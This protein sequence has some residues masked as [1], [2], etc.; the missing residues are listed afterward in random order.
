ME[1][2]K[3]S[4]GEFQ[5]DRLTDRTFIRLPVRDLGR[6]RAVGWILLGMAA[7]GG[8]FSMAW[9]FNSILPGIRM[10]ADGEVFAI[11]QLLFGIFGLTGLVPAVLCFAFG[12]AILQNRVRGQ[13]EINDRELVYRES[14]T[15]F[16]KRVARIKLVDLS[17]F[18]LVPFAWQIKA[19]SGRETTAATSLFPHDWC[20]LQ[21]VMHSQSNGDDKQLAM[22]A[23]GY[24]YEVLIALA[25]ILIGEIGHIAKRGGIN[26]SCLDWSDSVGAGKDGAT[27]RHGAEATL[28]VDRVRGTPIAVAQPAGSRIEILRTPGQPTVFRLPAQGLSGHALRLFSFGCVWNGIVLLMTI[29]FIVVAISNPPIEWAFYMLFPMGLALFGSIGVAVLVYSLSLA[30]RTAMI[31]IDDDQLFCETKGL[32]K[33][34][35]IEIKRSE[36]ESISVEHSGTEVNDV[37]LRQLRIRQRGPLGK[38]TPMFTGLPDNE[39]DWICFE[40]QR[41]LGLIEMSNDRGVIS[42]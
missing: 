15:V 11:G 32:R 28:V 1:P 18:E 31:G 39:L 7:F 40:L 25:P 3:N 29:I 36:I 21:A 22:M 33:T 6:W 30:R 5:V 34:T 14:A 16:S 35:W 23:L 4:N 12:R 2:S 38:Q 24:P 20:S 17:R 42:T 37:P 27:D 19:S 9:I 10:L 8:V 26:L 41:E 13:I